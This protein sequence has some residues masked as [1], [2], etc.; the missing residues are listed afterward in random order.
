MQK[1]NL[2]LIGLAVMGENLALNFESRGYSVSVYNRTISKVDRFI[3]TKAKN[4]K[5]IPCYNIKDFVNSIEK[6]RKIMLMVKAGAP[7]DNTIDLLLPLLDKGDVIID[8]GNSNYNDTE[9]RVIKAQDMGIDYLGVGISGGE[10]GALKGP[11]IMPGGSVKAWPLVKDMLQAISAKVDNEPCCNWI[12]KNGS[13]HFVKMVHNGIEY[14]DMQLICEVYDIMRKILKLENDKI[15]NI[16]KNWNNGVL[17]SYL[18]DITKDILIKKDKDGEYLVDKVLDLAGQK[19]TGKWTAISSFEYGVSL[20]LIAE[21]VFARIISSEKDLRS[22]VSKEFKFNIKEYNEN[23]NLIISKLEKALF[24]AKIISYTQGFDLIKK[25]GIEKNW[26]LDLSQIALLWRGGCII[27]SRFLNNISEAYKKNKDLDLLILDPYFKN[28]IINNYN[29]LKD[30]VLLA[31]SYGIPT[32]SLSSALN[33]FDSLRTDKL[34]TNLLQAQRDYFGAH[35]YQ[36][37][38]SDRENRFH[39]NWG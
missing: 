31:T 5:F 29:S 39:S 27:R 23:T 18:I 34:P 14:G 10:E 13:G 28:I 21:A 16:F 4:K 37:I 33:W 30:I 24:A 38:D 22:K 35:T 2:G 6:P 1:S 26:E 9:R 12:G 36:R 20:N 25:V 8:G 11:S 19:G 7:V 15:S 32:P 3:E 17:D